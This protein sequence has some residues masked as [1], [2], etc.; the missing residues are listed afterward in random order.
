VKEKRIQEAIKQMDEIE[1]QVSVAVD[2]FDRATQLWKKM[3]EDQQ[4]QHWD[5]EEENISVDIKDLKQR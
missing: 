2:L 5:Q 3:E 4:V 1:R